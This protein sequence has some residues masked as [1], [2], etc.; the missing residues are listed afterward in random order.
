[1]QESNHEPPKKRKKSKNTKNNT[2]RKPKRIELSYLLQWLLCTNLPERHKGSGGEWRERDD[3]EVK[4]N[5]ARGR[6]IYSVRVGEGARIGVLAAAKME[7]AH[8]CVEF[9]SH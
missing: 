9:P 6:G 8:P 1:M 3:F 2:P 4:R 7:G 5:A